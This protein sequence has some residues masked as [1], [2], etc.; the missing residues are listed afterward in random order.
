[1]GRTSYV[2]VNSLAVRRPAPWVDAALLGAIAAATL[3]AATLSRGA[4]SEPRLPGGQLSAY[5]FTIRLPPGWD[6]RLTQV[7]RGGTIVLEAAT[8]EI[9]ED[10]TRSQIHDSMAPEDIYLS[11]MDTQLEPRNVAADPS[12]SN[13]TAIAFASV[14]ISPIFQN[15]TLPAYAAKF[16]VIAGR[17]LMA[18]IGFGRTPTDSDL[19][20]A[21]LVLGGLRV[22]ERPS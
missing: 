7:A 21:N 9:A 3:I 17:P 1:M 13:A 15:V 14:D 18:Y 10:A 5:G 20:S 6:G 12:W 11:V 19:D 2:R 8:V 4:D 16:V 22:E